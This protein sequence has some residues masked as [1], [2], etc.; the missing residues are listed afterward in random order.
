[1]FSLC[2][3]ILGKYDYFDTRSS[4]VDDIDVEI[5]FLSELGEICQRIGSIFPNLENDANG[6]ISELDG[7]HGMARVDREKL[8]RERENEEHE[9]E[10][11]WYYESH[12]SA[13]VSARPAEKPSA[14]IPMVKLGEGVHQFRGVDA[15]RHL[16]DDL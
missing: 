8:E 3:G 5:E 14:P 1:M 11:Y 13:S 9:L 7:Q 12:K 4:T 2:I 6:V 16:F 15:V 10:A